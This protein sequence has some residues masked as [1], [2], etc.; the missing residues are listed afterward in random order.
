MQLMTALQTKMPQIYVD[1]IYPANGTKAQSY[2][3]E[4][5]RGDSLLLVANGAI[6]SFTALLHVKQLLIREAP[7][8]V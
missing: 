4:G 1:I 6:N 5:V 7:C 8:M 2:F 3:Q